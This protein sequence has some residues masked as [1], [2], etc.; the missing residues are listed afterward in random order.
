MVCPLR[1]NSAAEQEQA[2]SEFK[3]FSK[4]LD[5]LGTS[6]SQFFGKPLGFV[7]GE[8]IWRITSLALSDVALEFDDKGSF[9]LQLLRPP[10]TR[11]KLGRVSEDAILPDDPDCHSW[12]ARLE[13][14]SST[15]YRGIESLRK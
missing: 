4:K 12:F 5:R 13:Q 9:Y 10:H 2:R 1:R 14:L 11:L 6:C 7:H 15:F 3:N 8:K